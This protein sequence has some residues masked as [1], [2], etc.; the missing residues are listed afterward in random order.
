MSKKRDRN[1]GEPGQELRH[2][3]TECCEA[4]SRL[5]PA[6]E[7]NLD[8]VGIVEHHI[9]SKRCLELQ[10]APFL[11]ALEEVSDQVPIPVLSRFLP[12][13]CSLRS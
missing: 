1:K 11:G 9:V 2:P 12:S 8:E 10:P 3:C 5:P 13:L 6:R 4:P 7:E